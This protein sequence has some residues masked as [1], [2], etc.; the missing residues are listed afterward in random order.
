MANYTFHT[1]TVVRHVWSL[2]VPVDHE[3]LTKMLTVARN[4]IAHIY[5]KTDADIAS[6]ELMVEVGDEEV[7]LVHTRVKR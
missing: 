5:E 2:R 1:E 6:T 3:E 7:L 4:E